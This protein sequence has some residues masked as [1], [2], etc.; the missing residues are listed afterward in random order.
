MYSRLF[1]LGSVFRSSLKCV[2]LWELLGNLPS[3]K[4]DPIK[5]KCTKLKE[6][7]Q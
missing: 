7:L 1:E 4:D 2:I 3:W 5:D 6:T